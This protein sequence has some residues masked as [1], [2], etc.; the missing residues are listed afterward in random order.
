[1]TEK[2]KSPKYR[3]EASFSC[4]T[5]MH[6]VTIKGGEALTNEEVD[7]LLAIV[8]TTIREYVIPGCSPLMKGAAPGNSMVELVHSY[9]IGDLTVTVFVRL[10]LH[11][12]ERESKLLVALDQGMA[13]LQ[14]FSFKL[15]EIWEV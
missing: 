4:G 11:A 5:F 15:A 14:N 12:S 8:E 10:N 1:M 3:T 6:S 7:S 9:S 2:E 13:E